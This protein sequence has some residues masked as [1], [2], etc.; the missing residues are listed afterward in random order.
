MAEIYLT[1]GGFE[2]LRK[3]L[4]YLKN[5]KRREISKAIGEARL[6]GD[7]SENAEYDAAKE[8]QGH[9]EARIAELEGKLSNVRIIED[10]NIPA[11]KIYIGARVTLLDVKSSEEVQYMLVS[12]EEADFEA[13][14]LSM[15]SPIGK[16]L[17]G[18]AVGQEVELEVPAGKLKYK[19]LKIERP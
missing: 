1:R 15:L 2:K 18:K 7:L 4:E 8:A 14:K 5:T 12:P 6:Q 10:L 17:M 3:E 19:I 9:C 11:D 16:G 13:N